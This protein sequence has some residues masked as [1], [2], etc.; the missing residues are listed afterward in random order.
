M[1]TIKSPGVG[2][3]SLTDLHESGLYPSTWNISSNSGAVDS[4]SLGS[5]GPAG[6][7]A[8]GDPTTLSVTVT[9]PKGAT[10][11]PVL[12]LRVTSSGTAPDVFSNTFGVIGPPSPPPNGP[13]C[14][15]C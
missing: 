14:P 4:G 13:Q 7:Q 1:T 5:Y 2:T 8:S 15:G 9:V 10:S 6:W 11:N 3:V 12:T